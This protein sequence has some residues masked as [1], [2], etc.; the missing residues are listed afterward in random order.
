M[1]NALA[2]EQQALADQ[3]FRKH[4]AEQKKIERDQRIAEEEQQKQEIAKRNLDYQKAKIPIP[5]PPPRELQ[6]VFR[7]KNEVL[8]RPL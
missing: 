7:D 2:L 4:L 8:Q 6:K 3:N 1:E 5:L